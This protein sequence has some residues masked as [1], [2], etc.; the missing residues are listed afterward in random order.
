MPGQVCGAWTHLQH[1]FADVP[2]KFCIAALQMA[3][4]LSGLQRDVLT[5]Y[6]A[7]LKSALNKQSTQDGAKRSGA[8]YQLG[9]LIH[10]CIAVI[11]T[12]YNLIVMYHS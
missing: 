3:M 1:L 2:S 8:L 10:R 9:D 6:K 12:V 7:L 11:L 5:L 4:R